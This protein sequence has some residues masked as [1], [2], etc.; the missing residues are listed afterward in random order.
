[1][2]QRDVEH[3]IGRLITDEEFR[4]EFAM[5]PRRTLRDLVE[6]GVGL[7]AAEVAALVATDRTVWQQAARALDPR[8]QKASLRRWRDRRAD[9]DDGVE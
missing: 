9:D 6:H 8:L 3:L 2:S 7:T 1:M 4:H 5:D